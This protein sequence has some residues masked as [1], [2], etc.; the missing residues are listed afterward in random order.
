MQGVAKYK[1]VPSGEAEIHPPWGDIGVSLTPGSWGAVDDG[2]GVASEG[3]Y[4]YTVT[5]GDSTRGKPTRLNVWDWQDGSLIKK[6]DISSWWDNPEEARSSGRPDS[7]PNTFSCRNDRLFL[8]SSGSCFMQMVCPILGM[9]YD[10]YFVSWANGNGDFFFDRN[11]EPDAVKKWECNDPSAG[12]DKF[13]LE[14]DNKLFAIAPCDA[15]DAASFGLIAPDGTG[16][17]YMNFY[18]ESAGA[19][20]FD[21]IC[22]NGSIYDGIYC[23]NA[24]GNGDSA[25]I[26]YVAQDSF[27]GLLRVDWW[28]SVGDVPSS[29]FIWAGIR[30][31]V[32]CPTTID[33]SIPKAGKVTVDVYN[34]T[35]QKVA[36][37]ANGPM[38]AGSHSVIWNAGKLSAGL[39]FATVKSGPLSRTVKMTLLK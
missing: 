8:S 35:G 30:Q 34:T 32:Q 24:S 25:G 17:G 21:F 4:L 28:D 37:L 11:Y 31:S 33:F 14:A 6:F 19:N 26:W 7:G 3:Y 9:D 16:A 39:Y 5:R 29:D 18:G 1:W 20:R 2:A 12:L 15:G 13:T 27:K 38:T 10:D 36:A 22:D 23:N